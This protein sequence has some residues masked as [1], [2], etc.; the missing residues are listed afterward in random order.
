MKKIG[1]LLASIT[2]ITGIV[3]GG[4]SIL[5]RAMTMYV[6]YRVTGCDFRWSGVY[7]V[8]K[9][10]TTQNR[11]GQGCGLTLYVGNGGVTKSGRRNIN[12]TYSQKGWFLDVDS[13][14]WYY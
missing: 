13:D 9:G 8:G 3:V 7:T 12:L 6:S 2:V 4:G 10:W 1:K 11:S 14:H 5:A